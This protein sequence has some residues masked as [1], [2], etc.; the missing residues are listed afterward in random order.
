[1]V[2]QDVACTHLTL[3]YIYTP[4][5]ISCVVGPGTTKSAFECMFFQPILK[6]VPT[7]RPQRMFGVSEV[8]RLFRSFDAWTTSTVNTS[9]QGQHRVL[10]SNP[11]EGP[12][13]VVPALY[14]V[15]E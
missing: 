7:W 11:V 5:K 4:K 15:I 9:R 1:M 12:L 6:K 10:S 13:F 2:V 8:P 3:V 14:A